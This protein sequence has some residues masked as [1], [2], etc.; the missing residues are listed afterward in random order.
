MTSAQCTCLP[1]L[2]QL[3]DGVS[4]ATRFLYGKHDV[5][6]ASSTR[7]LT[8]L[9]R[10]VAVWDIGKA[11]HFQATGWEEGE[12]VGHCVNLMNDLGVKFR[13]MIHRSNACECKANAAGC[14]LVIAWYS[15]SLGSRGLCTFSFP[16]SWPG[17]FNLTASDEISIPCVL[18]TFYTG[19]AYNDAKTVYVC[20]Y[21]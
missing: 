15:E 18:H 2:S 7:K 13:L 12:G 6:S 14:L 4:R 16:L 21:A 20:S 17:H 11:S 3:R 9:V 1:C 5:V 19:T 8:T 10:L